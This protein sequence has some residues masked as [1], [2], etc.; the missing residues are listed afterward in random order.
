MSQSNPPENATTVRV[1]ELDMLLAPLQDVEHLQLWIQKHL[2]FTL[3]DCR[4]TEYADMTPAEFVWTV[5]RAIMDGTPLNI[6]GVSGRDGSK[7]VSLSVIDLLSILHDQRSAVHFGMIL[8]QAKRAR[9]YLEK[10]IQKIPILSAALVRE[11][12]KELVLKIDGAEVG[13]EILPCTKTAA[14]GAHAALVSWDE[15]GSADGPKL[16]AGYRDSAGVPGAST[17]GKPAVTVKISSRHAADSLVEAEIKAAEA[18][19]GLG[20]KVVKWT[21]LDCTEQCTDAR[22][23]TVPTPLYIDTMKGL[24]AT[25]AEYV[26]LPSQA[27]EG[28]Q[29]SNDTMDGCVKCPLVTLC[30][31][32]LR[33]QTSKSVLLRKIDDVITKYR[34][35]GS[36]EWALS[37][38]MSLRASPEALVY[39][40]FSRERHVPGWDVMWE[41]LTGR[42]PVAPATRS[43]FV[44]EAMKRCEILSGQDF[45]WSSPSTCVTVA[46]DRKDNVYVLDAFGRTYCDD[47]EFC[48]TVKEQAHIPYQVQMHIPDP[49]N[50]SALS[51][52]RKFPLEMPVAEVSKAAGSV[53]GGINVIKA[54]LRV[55]GTNNETKLFIAP[56]LWA[57]DDQLFPGLIEEFGMYRWPIE[58]DGSID[59]SGNPEKG[60]DHFLDA[61]RYVLFWRFGKDIGTMTLLSGVAPPPADDRERLLRD[62]AMQ[63]NFSYV[64]NREDYEAQKRSDDN[65]DD[66]DG[67]DGPKGG[68]GGGLTW[69]WT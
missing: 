58:V 7:T 21:T 57:S 51:I 22:S 26:E 63:G 46:I 17:K 50:Q 64:D 27:Q 19:A 48:N 65:D 24:I 49:E 30:K 12:S 45:G 3:P 68:G 40:H 47:P 20:A 43:Q 25:E 15:I 10:Y 33:H 38:L 4:V 62:A 29:L 52:M 28:Y 55:P 9:S 36:H 54:L 37:Q 59:D 67:D 39:K 11:N 8:P 31:G 56:D 60:N 18:D 66:D 41:R 5:Y 6:I 13:L 34:G 23:G 32:K 69:G 14:Q 1:S 2:G 61:L 53:R 35:G 44:A 16:V 42:K